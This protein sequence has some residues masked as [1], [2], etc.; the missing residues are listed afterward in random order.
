MPSKRRRR[1]DELDDVSEAANGCNMVHKPR[2]DSV[3]SEAVVNEKTVSCGVKI[4]RT[5]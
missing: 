3:S 1:S 2:A 5:D 4:S